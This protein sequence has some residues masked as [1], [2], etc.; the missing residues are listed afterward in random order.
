[1]T[2]PV[3]HCHTRATVSGDPRCLTHGRLFSECE[4][5]AVSKGG[6]AL[7]WRKAAPPG[8][9]IKGTMR[10]DDGV[11]PFDTTL[12]QPRPIGPDELVLGGSVV[13][14][15]SGGSDMTVV[16]DHIQRE[17]LH[18][19]W[20]TSDGYAQYGQCDRA[21]LWLISEPEINK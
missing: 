7:D 11:V 10:F 2:E 6:Y 9:R 12:S 1:M 13:R 15:R 21:A 16:R 3:L 5:E 20:H 18:L 19:V 4:A 8:L 17:V 14:L